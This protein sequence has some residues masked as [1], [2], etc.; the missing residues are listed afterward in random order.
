MEIEEG[1]WVGRIGRLLPWLLLLMMVVVMMMVTLMIVIEVEPITPLGPFQ[2][3]T[4]VAWPDNDVK[5][6]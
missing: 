4:V 5:W 3:V 6:Q 1:S 2:F